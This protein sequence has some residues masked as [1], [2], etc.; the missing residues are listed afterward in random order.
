MRVYVISDTHLEMRFENNIIEIH[1]E[2]ENDVLALCGDIGY[3]H[4]NN[5]YEFVR[6]H[7]ERFYH[8]FIVTGNHEYYSRTKQ[9]S[10][11]EIE[12]YL[13]ALCAKF[14]NVTYLQETT[15]TLGDYLFVGCTLWTHVDESCQSRMNDYNQVYLDD[16]THPE[17]RIEYETDGLM[18]VK[19]KYFNPYK[20]QLRW[21]DVVQIH[22]RHEE[23]LKN[24][25]ESEEE[26]K[27]VVLTHHPPSFR[28]TR[29]DNIAYASHCDDLIK[30]P[31]ICWL[32]GHTHQ[33]TFI[34]I[35][36]IPCVSNCYGYP[37]ERDCD[38]RSGYYVELE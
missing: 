2:S 5:Y 17:T 21:M 18:S 22:Q 11:N 8:I 28:M 37:T 14:R 38:Y 30:E 10:M 1:P 26:K 34:E 27:I 31:V 20:R 7:S 19:A 6:R 13:F 9:Y 33:S 16:S 25:I 15:Y 35:N 12:H 36:G 23:W 3:P 4:D 32:S 24:V 29:K